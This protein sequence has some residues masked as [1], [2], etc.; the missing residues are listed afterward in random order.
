[1]KALLPPNPVEIGDLLR[2]KRKLRPQSACQP[3]RLRKVK[4]SY[5]QPCQTCV[6]RDHSELCSYDQ[7]TKRSK[8]ST[9]LSQSQLELVE[10]PEDSEQWTPSKTEWMQIHNSLG[11]ITATLHQV[12]G[13]LRRLVNSK[14]LRGVDGHD[15]SLNESPEHSGSNDGADY[16]G[17]GIPTNNLLTGGDVYLGSKSVPAMVMALSRDNGDNTN[18]AAVQE[19]L[20]RSV[21]PIFALDNESATYP[22]VDL[23]GVPH[24]SMRRLELLCSV[25]PTDADCHQI[26]RQY[27]D[28]A[29]VIYPVTVN[30]DH[31]EGELI[32]FLTQRRDNLKFV[33]ET[34]LTEM[35]VFGKNVHWLGLLFAVLASGLQCSNL[36][37]KEK[38]A[39]SQV[40][41]TFGILW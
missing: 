35:Q 5:D 37:R 9:P 24:G 19:L 3:C 8:T 15:A 32:D 16:N 41:G 30:I 40:Y 28:I 29:Y 33:P 10:P 36:P 27:H 26:F 31:F 2:Q 12:Q 39:K 38:H 21:L 17:H 14:E 23:W 13:D 20:H 1:M 22:F 7:A 34:G 25:L 18:N 4:C 11:A 6:E